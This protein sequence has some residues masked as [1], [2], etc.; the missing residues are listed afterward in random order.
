LRRPFLILAL[1]LLATV[2]FIPCVR[3]QQAV[4]PQSE[5]D[6][7]QDLVRAHR[8]DEGLA[9]LEPELKRHPRDLKALNLAG[10][11]CTGKGDIHQADEYFRRALQINPTFVPALK[12]LAI[13][14]YTQHDIAAAAKHLGQASILQPDDPVVNLY[15]GE[16]AY[17]NRDFKTAVEKLNAAQGFVSRSDQLKADLAISF[18]Q[19]GKPADALVL[20]DE[21]QPA[22]L[23]PST[24]FAAGLALA[25][26]N[27]PDRAVVFFLILQKRFPDSYNT[28]FNL[29]QCYIASKRYPEAI[30]LANQW[31]SGGHDTSELENAVSGAY[32]HTHQTPKAIEA[33]RRA[34]ELDPENDDNY[35]D[36][37]NLCIEHRDF[38]NGLKVMEVGLKVHPKSSRLIFERGVLYAMEDEF[39]RAEQDFEES[40]RL[41]PAT[42]F[43][44]V[45]M[46]VTYLE[47]GNAAK[48][49]E[50]LRQRLKQKPNDASL[51]Y[52]LGEAL[53]RNGAQP[54]DNPYREAQ[55]AFERSIQFNGSLCL[56]HVALGEIYIDE[57]RFKD[58]VD[59][60]EKARA[61]DPK[62]KSAYSHLAV[63]YRRLGDKENARRTLEMLKD[64][65][66]QEEGW[67]HNRM[68]AGE[69]GVSISDSTNSN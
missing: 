55:S 18:L 34:I 40:A 63:A 49:I 21:L 16:I 23:T 11:A 45:G 50:L 48:A 47:T 9:I 12:N 8:W 19:T 61:I 7:A 67:M 2:Q 3:S 64:L 38:A 65:H 57:G 37:A 68:K 42:N 44:F 41:A 39:D 25:Q 17:A 22:D 33:L 36:F 1:V 62:E 10:L 60:L 35:L 32:E 28:A 5:Y 53:M 20:M 30:A 59:Q 46:G 26:D 31:I 52:L 4:S 66:E 14:E 15:L 27:L 6:R 54:G 56:P 69:E 43:G 29:I 24:Q 51:L 58:A 13:N